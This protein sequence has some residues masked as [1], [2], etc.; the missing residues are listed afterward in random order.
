MARSGNAEIANWLD[1]A[2][3]SDLGT[4][5]RR[6]GSSA[7]GRS[8]PQVSAESDVVSRSLQGMV[9]FCVHLRS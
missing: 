5:G 4:D 3:V 6:P 9:A 1:E 7:K 2:A 8:I